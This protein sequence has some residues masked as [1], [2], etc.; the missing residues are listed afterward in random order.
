MKLR[1]F[2]TMLL[3]FVLVIILGIAGMFVAFGV[4][5]TMLGDRRPAV[6]DGYQRFRHASA[7]LMA[8]YYVAQGDSWTGIDQRLDDLS[9]FG[10]GPNGPLLVDAEGRV[11]AGAR[12]VQVGV[13][14]EP[15]LLA[16]GEPIVVDGRQVGTL[17]FG[18]VT[19]G[20]GHNSSGPPPIF[21]SMLRGTLA[22]VLGL[23]AVMLGLAVIFAGRISQ[24][25]R[26][27]TAAAQALA[28]GQLDVRVPRAS[29]REIDELAG[30]F[31]AMASSLDDADRQRRQ[32]T[33]DI[34]H[35][36]RTPLS[37]IKGRLMGIQ[38]GVYA[39]DASQLGRL[40]DETA[41]LERLIDDLRLLA[42]AEAGQLPLYIEPSD[43]RELLD[44][45]AA[46]FAGEAAARQVRLV[47]EAGDGLPP[48]LV[49]SQRMVQ[50][51]AN[52]TANAL[53]HT[54]AGGQVTLR[55][56][57]VNRDGT[58]D[59]GLIATENLPQITLQVADTGAGISPD[60]LPHI[61][62]RFYRADKARTRGASG[63]SG[64]GLAISR[65]IV[66]AHGG[67]I[68]ATSIHGTGTTLTIRL[69]AEAAAL[70][71]ADNR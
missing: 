67:S 34:A 56:A 51:L 71:I 37:I 63:G 15:Q 55:A 10:P 41:L 46:A 5:W 16:S 53:R 27:L 3:A 40:L 24:P 50:V 25:V 52:L 17:M 8:D 38:D 33:A 47:V 42:L 57:V 26:Q 11:I 14:L 70:P 64:L 58:T 61:F 7:E 19:I 31:N 21:W 12:R 2:W 6:D 68:Q 60:D 59:S 36:L 69:P 30:A 48:A 43:P 1:L 44:D 49:D 9:Y 20:A 62:E 18:D 65:Q 29:V 22:G 4:A 13:R 39:P 45:T 35:E 54:P 28:A 66:L 32:L 23:T